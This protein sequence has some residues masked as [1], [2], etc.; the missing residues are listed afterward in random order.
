MSTLIPNTPNATIDLK[1][2]HE[3]ICGHLALIYPVRLYVRPEDIRPVTAPDPL[4]VEKVTA[5]TK[6][7]RA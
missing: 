5:V 1:E 3:G 4:R 2:L 7:A 6:D